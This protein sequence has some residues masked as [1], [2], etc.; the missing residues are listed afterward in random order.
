M[1]SY[2][3][4]SFTALNITFSLSEYTLF[5]LLLAQI[6]SILW[7]MAVLQVRQHGLN[8]FDAI[9]R[10]FLPAELFSINTNEFQI[11]DST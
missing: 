9:V 1:Q 7:K 4:R 6:T 2:I 5:A 11:L 10:F 8:K 3:T